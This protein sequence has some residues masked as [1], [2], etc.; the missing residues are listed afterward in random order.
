MLDMWYLTF[1][2]CE[3]FEYY[4]CVICVC[5]V[6]A[7]PPGGPKDNLVKSR[8]QGG[9]GRYVLTKQEENENLKF[10][11]H[12]KVWRR[13]CPCLGF[14]GITTNT[15]QTK[16]LQCQSEKR[17]SQHYNTFYIS[18]FPWDGPTIEFI[19]PLSCFNFYIFITTGP[20]LSLKV[21]SCISR[22]LRQLTHSFPSLCF[23]FL[24]F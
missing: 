9:W 22:S 1:N 8:A 20:S 23:R 10:Y 2:I 7:L 3:M 12:L 17:Q 21:Y 16:R 15:F 11:S 13:K 6:L 14:E 5:E 4:I 24:S 18:N 19:F